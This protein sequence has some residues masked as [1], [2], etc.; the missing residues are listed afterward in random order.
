MPNL[1]KNV[2][3]AFKR[4]AADECAHVADMRQQMAVLSVADAPSAAQPQLDGGSVKLEERTT[5]ELSAVSEREAFTGSNGQDHRVSIVEQ[6][7][8]VEGSTGCEET[9]NKDHHANIA[10]AEADN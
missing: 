3:N 5:F 6:A 7:K 8:L 4:F 2:L 1:E 10:F 9:E